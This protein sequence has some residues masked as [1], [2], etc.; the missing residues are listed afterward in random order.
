MDKTKFIAEVYKILQ[1]GLSPKLTYHSVLHTK[2]VHEVC[3]FYARFYELS[4]LDTDLLEIAAVSHD[5]GFVKTYDEHEKESVRMI[6][7]MMRD[8]GFTEQDIERVSEMILATKIPQSPQSFLSQILCDADLDYLG[9]ADFV[10]IGK[11]LK[12]EWQNY[13][14]VKNI[15]DMFDQ[16]QIGFLKIHSY[17]TPYAVKKRKP[18][19]LKNLFILEN[20]D[21]GPETTTDLF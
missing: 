19:K 20:P 21:L 12:K 17:H 13:D 7:P 15:E 5:M 11:L 4:P 9:R 18:R 1:E 8:R 10:P 16:I 3:K 6:S 14:R 2:D